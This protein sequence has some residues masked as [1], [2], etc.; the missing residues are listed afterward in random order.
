MKNNWEFIRKK[1]ENDNIQ[2]RSIVMDADDAIVILLFDDWHVNIDNKW[3]R[4]N[5]SIIS[6]LIVT[7]LSNKHMK[8]KKRRKDWKI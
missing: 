4:A 3:W 8:M 6:S 7:G 5:D 1:F 2:L